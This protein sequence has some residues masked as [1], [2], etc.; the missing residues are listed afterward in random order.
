[1]HMLVCKR[2][3]VCVC[4]CLCA[5]A[6]TCMHLFL[7]MWILCLCV[8]PHLCL[9]INACVFSCTYIGVCVCVCVC[10]D[11]FPF[12]KLAEAFGDSICREVREAGSVT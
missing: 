3:C 12:L 5:Y 11:C 7:F 10:M 8:W 9:F 2:V 6:Y 4:V 1:M